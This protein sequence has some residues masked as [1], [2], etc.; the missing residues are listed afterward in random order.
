MK[1]PWATAWVTLVAV[2]VCSCGQRDE[3]G[4]RA[5]TLVQVKV[6]LLPYASHA[7]LFIAREEGYFREQGLDVD[8]EEMRLGAEAL[9]LLAQGHL[10]VWAGSITVG[11]ANLVARGGRIRLVAGKGY[12][13]ADD[14]SIAGLVRPGLLEKGRLKP[15][16]VRDGITIS[17]AHG[18]VFHFL[19]DRLLAQEAPDVEVLGRKPLAPFL[20]AE[21]LR[22]GAVDLGLYGEPWKT[23][24]LSAGDADL[25]L[26][27]DQVAPGLQT[28]AIAFG[29]RLLDDDPETGRRFMV[30]Y[31]KGARQY[32]LGK[33]DRNVALMVQLTSLGPELVREMAWPMVRADGR[34]NV[35]SL[36]EFQQWAVEKGLQDR[37]VD[38]SDYWEPSFVEHAQTVLGPIE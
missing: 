38:A 22:T 10:D 19:T 33:T 4:S 23:R 9:P 26:S 36:L 27:A 29:P 11:L 13:G 18:T 1:G 2:V 15:D 34:L 31:V 30:A 25:W 21:A 5:Q 35:E 8:F 12:V 24:L 37:V 14:P 20:A 28:A 7:P 32:N 3:P 17:C 16:E 6:L